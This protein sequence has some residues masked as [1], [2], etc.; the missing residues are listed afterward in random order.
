MPITKVSLNQTMRPGEI[1]AINT[2]NEV[3]DVVNDLDLTTVLNRLSTVEN[4]VTALNT[5]V[6][7]PDAP[8]NGLV[9][10]VGALETASSGAAADITQ[11]KRTLYT[12]LNQNVPD[13]S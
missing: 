2:L 5:T 8:A 6:Y 10:K 7:S 13:P 4:S 11:I 1:S 9:S 12:P 3:I